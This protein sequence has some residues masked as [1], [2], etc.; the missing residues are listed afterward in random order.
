MTLHLKQ[1]VTMAN[2]ARSAH[3]TPLSQKLMQVK[4]KC[5]CS[6]DGE[7]RERNNS[8]S[9]LGGRSTIVEGFVMAAVRDLMYDRVL[10]KLKLDQLLYTDM[11][12]V[13]VFQDKRNPSH[14]DLLTSDMLGDL[15]DKYAYLLVENLSWY[16]NKFMAFGPK[17]YQLRLKDLYTGKILWWDKTMKG[18]SMKRNSNLFSIESSF[19]Y[20]TGFRFLFN[21]TIWIRAIFLQ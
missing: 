21:R 13:I 5:D 19:I 3:S 10:S 8:K 11:D 18:I 12:N 20:E 7:N 9:S 14:V 6:I 16:I 2:G 1:N 17:M 15:K 4:L